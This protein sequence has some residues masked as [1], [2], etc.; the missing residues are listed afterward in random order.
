MLTADRLSSLNR[1]TRPA[2][3]GGCHALRLRG[4]ASHL[5][6]LGDSAQGAR[7]QGSSTRASQRRFEGGARFVPVLTRK[8]GV[9]KTTITALLGMALADVARRPHHR[10]RRQP[11]PRHARRARRQADPRD[12]ARRRARRRRR[13]AATPTSPTLVSR[14]ETRLDILAS[15][16][17]PTALRGVRRERLQRRRRPRRPLLLDRAHRLRH[18]HRALGH[19]RHAAAR[20]LDR[21]R[22]GRQRRRGAARL[23]DAHLARGER[24]RR[25]GAQRRRR[26]QHGDAGHQPRQARRDRGALPVARARDR[27][28][29]VRPAARRRLG[30]PLERTPA[31]HAARG[32]R[33]R[34]ARR[35]RPARATAG[36]DRSAIDRT[37]HP[38]VRRPRPATVSDPI[39]PVD[40]RVRALVDDLVDSVRLPG[41]A[42][43]AAPQIGVEPARVQLQ[44]RRRGR[45]RPQPRA[46]SRSRAS[47]SWST[48]AASRC[49]A[50]GSRRRATRSPGSRG[51]DLDGNPIELCGRRA[52]WRRRCSTRPTTSTACSTSSGSSRTSASGDA[53][54]ARVGLVLTSRARAGRRRP[55]RRRAPRMPRGP[56]CVSMLSARSRWPSVAGA[57]EYMPSIT[58]AKSSRMTLRLMLSFGVRWPLASVS[59]VART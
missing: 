3:E 37:T 41:R 23:R 53:G 20:R 12:R 17:D 34:R 35:R 10:D 9:G 58:S 15:D 21:H 38:P 6:N 14:D 16:T 33:A 46:S 30:R 44:R 31:R 29:P 42:G 57:P 49:P 56:S 52:S 11:R 55:R 18:R 4:H 47:P 2:P 43:V 24:L 28:D 25:A 27:A 39:G 5:V 19:A 26:D 32:T 40:D 48:R 8:G 13:S 22:L 36:T 51:I 45:L 1:T 54:G 50:S 7:A 59:S